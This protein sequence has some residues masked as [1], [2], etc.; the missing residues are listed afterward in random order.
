MVSHDVQLPTSTPEAHGVPAAAIVAFIDAAEARGLELHS[1]MLLRHGHI[2]AEGWW[3]PYRAEEPHMLFSLSKSFAATAIGLAVAEGRL[4]VDDP[5]LPFFADEA[6][7]EPGEGLEAMRVRHL[8]SMATGHHE[9]TTGALREA[10]DGDW[11]RAFLAQPVD[12]AP[13]TYFV[14]NSGAT[15]MLSAI[16]QRLTGTTL[17]DYLRPRLLDPLGIT[18][19]T[20]ETCPRGVNTGGWGLSITTA[21]I[22]RFGQLYLQEGVW[23][24]R[25][26]L[27]AGWVA[28]ATTAQ[29]DNSNHPSGNP[30]WMQGYGYQFW[31]CRH[32]AYRGDGAF[33]QFCV[34]MPEQEAVLVT[35]SGLTTM[36]AV[37]DLAWEHLLPALGAD[38]LPADSPADEALARRLAGL[39][40]P[41]P[42]DAATSPTA[43]QLSGRTFAFAANEQG[44]ETIR[45][46]FA[47]DRATITITDAQGAHTLVAGNGAWLDGTANYGN[48]RW[49]ASPSASSPRAAAAAGAWTDERTF[50]LRL[51]YTNTP[52]GF[53]LVSRFTAEGVSLDY[54]ENVGFGPTE[55]PRLTGHPI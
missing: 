44:V 50:E 31:R 29:S 40:L 13:G 8:L 12:H 38:A 48:S 3:T 1:L 37:L 55:R 30:D 46:D 39:A 49:P 19:A 25:Q 18:E 26:L 20:W 42:Q 14:Y 9:D 5:V 7:A 6:P 16:I 28:E 34:I 4:T 10:E 51:R 17:L 11:A 35:T 36:Q 24:G 45:Y 32:D 41:T 53:A 43:A 33:G 27:P 2:L 22:A 47:A 54:R 23:E 15:Y 52:F 21:S